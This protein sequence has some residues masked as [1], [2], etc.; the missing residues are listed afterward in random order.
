MLKAL[1]KIP[2][3]HLDILSSSFRKVN[4]SNLYYEKESLT[5][6]I[7]M[8]QAL[9]KVLGKNGKDIGGAD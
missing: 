8:D 4:N 5:L 3:G 1:R 2:Q 9:E 6:N 7:N